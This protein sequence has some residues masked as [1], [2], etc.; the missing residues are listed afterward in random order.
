MPGRGEALYDAKVFMAAL[1]FLKPLMQRLLSRLLE[2]VPVG[3]IVG[4][5]RTGG[6]RVRTGT[7]RAVLSH[8]PPRDPN[9]AVRL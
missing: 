8:Q 1:R 9:D 7:G 4:A 3:S 5:I 2:A 6:M